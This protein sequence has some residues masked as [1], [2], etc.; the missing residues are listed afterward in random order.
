[1]NALLA[2]TAR[3]MALKPFHG[4]V[5][6]LTS[7]LQDIVAPFPKWALS[8]WDNRW[9][10]AFVYYCVIQSGVN[11]PYH[12]PSEDMPCHFGGC[13]AWEVYAKRPEVNG[14]HDAR[15][16]GFVPMA[17][18]IVLYDGVFENK[19]HDHIG[20]VLEN[21]DDYLVVAE[22]NVGN[23]SAVVTREKD[24]RIRSYLRLNFK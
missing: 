7:N 20:I 1:M 4:N 5:M 15:E 21:G 18:D 22:G 24:N 13:I 16:E 11:L 12:Y 14:Y 6:G 8:N 19:P 2:E 3:K 10:A 23:I 9:C 17:G